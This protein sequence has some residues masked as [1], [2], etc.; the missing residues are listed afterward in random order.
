MAKPFL[1]FS[2]EMNVAQLWL[3]EK[4]KDENLCQALFILEMDNDIKLNYKTHC[5][6][7]KISYYREEKLAL[8]FP[9]SFFQI[10]YLREKIVMNKKIY[11]IGLLYLGSYLELKAKDN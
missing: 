4:L 11:E 7:E 8:F 1:A 2:R 6:L 9:F 3:R 10:K 5:D